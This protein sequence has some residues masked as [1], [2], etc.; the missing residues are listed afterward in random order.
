MVGRAFIR[1]F[2]SCTPSAKHDTSVQAQPGSEGSVGLQTLPRRFRGGAP[3]RTSSDQDLGDGSLS[4]KGR[5][6]T[7]CM[8]ICGHLENVSI[9]R[10]HVEVKA[11]GLQL[12]AIAFIRSVAE[13]IAQAP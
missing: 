12:I 1:C 2:S 8:L 3:I 9:P 10:R 4:G 5:G 6:S 7:W 13:Q 11:A